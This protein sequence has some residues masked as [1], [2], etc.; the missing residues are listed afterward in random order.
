MLDSGSG[1]DAYPTYPEPTH[2]SPPVQADLHA[3]G[4][5]LKSRVNVH[6]DPVCCEMLK[7]AQMALFR[8]ARKHGGVNLTASSAAL[9]KQRDSGGLRAPQHL[10]GFRRDCD[11]H[12]RFHLHECIVLAG[13]FAVT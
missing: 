5:D 10:Q 2:E 11:G 3:L 1:G 12:C 7:G 6:I 4:A 9:L 8:L 13:A